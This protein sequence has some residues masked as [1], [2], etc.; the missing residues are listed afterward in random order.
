MKETIKFLIVCLVSVLAGF[1]CGFLVPER[2][3]GFSLCVLFAI[4]MS[5]CYASLTGMYNA[6]TGI[7]GSEIEETEEP[8]ETE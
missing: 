7:P 4:G 2:T 6:D 3:L 5:Y 1:F 8:E